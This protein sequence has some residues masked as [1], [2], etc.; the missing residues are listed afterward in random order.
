MNTTADI[1]SAARKLHCMGEQPSM[2]LMSR[3]AYA[4]LRNPKWSPL[5]GTAREK[6]RQRFRRRKVIEWVE[7]HLDNAPAIA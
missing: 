3:D 5:K 4:R 6:K 7:L 2:I 1:I